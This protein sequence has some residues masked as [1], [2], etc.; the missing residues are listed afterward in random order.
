[1]YRAGKPIDASCFALLIDPR[2]QTITYANAGHRFP[3]HVGA[4]GL[5]VLARA[6]CLLGDSGTTTYRETSAAIAPGDV[7]VLF[8]DGLIQT[9]NAD[10]VA[11]GERRL[12]KVLK[13]RLETDAG[14]RDAIVRSLE[15]HKGDQPFA[16]DTGLLVVRVDEGAGA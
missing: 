8:T 13:Q 15:E 3:Y 6:G 10:G 11:Y 5:G 14:A 7:V 9:Q 1:M 16:D 12:Q 4:S 2:A